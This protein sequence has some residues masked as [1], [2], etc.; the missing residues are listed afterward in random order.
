MDGDNR[1]LYDG[2][3]LKKG[4]CLSIDK[5][6][7]VKEAQNTSGGSGVTYIP[8]G[9]FSMQKV[10]DHCQKVQNRHYSPGRADST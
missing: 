9:Q 5:G 4:L 2:N 3:D 6:C 7:F 1:P 8:Q 10:L